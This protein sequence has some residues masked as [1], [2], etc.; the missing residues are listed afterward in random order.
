M[1]MI[2][3]LSISV[4]VDIF[5]NA[6]ILI[7]ILCEK[8]WSM[9]IINMKSNTFGFYDSIN[10]LC[11]GRT[12]EL[13]NYLHEGSKASNI[14]FHRSSLLH[15]H[16][17]NIPQ[18]RENIFSDSGVLTC[19]YAEYVTSYAVMNFIRRHA[20]LPM[21]ITLSNLKTTAYQLRVIPGIL[22]I[23]DLSCGKTKAMFTRIC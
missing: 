14:K 7:P 23:S 12:N 15:I 18:Q 3:I 19:M 20:Y 5:F 8:H 1:I 9:V 22:S 13:L 6:F 2:F 4:L 17:R 11:E 16:F 10:Y 21:K